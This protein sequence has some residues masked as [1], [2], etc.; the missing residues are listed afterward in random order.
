[1]LSNGM[2]VEAKGL[3]KTFAGREVIR[4]CSIHLPQGKIYGFLG[5]NGAGKTTVMKMLTG[6]LKP[7][8]GTAKVLG[9]DI[10]TQ[11]DQVL[12]RI[13]SLIEVPVFFEHLSA[14]KNLDLHLAY[15]NMEERDASQVLEMVG[16]S[17]TGQQPVSTF[18]LGMRQRLAIARAIVHKP[19]LLILDE[20]INGLDPLAIREMRVLFK[21]LVNDH[22][23]SILI[24][25]HIISELEYIADIIG[26]ILNG[27][28]VCEETM[29]DI[30]AQ[31]ENG[32]EEYFFKV[33][34][35]GTESA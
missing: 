10:L 25:S 9:M 17:H 33:T 29:T 23:M 24:S 3:V 8:A 32:L 31:F 18:S 7:T 22:G 28:V 6:L 13:G 4:N 26:I 20:P 19:Q 5:P 12:S 21:S 2:I 35:G 14:Q 16:L 30:Q 15:M 27:T 34:N 1:M 11:R